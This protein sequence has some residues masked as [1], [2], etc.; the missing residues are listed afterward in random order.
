MKLTKRIRG[1]I[2]EHRYLCRCSRCEDH[3]V[4]G[5]WPAKVD[6][7]DGGDPVTVLPHGSVT[8][9]PEALAGPLP[10]RVTK[11]DFLL[12]TQLHMS[13]LID[14]DTGFSRVFKGDLGDRVPAIA[15]AVGEDSVRVESTG[16]G[17]VVAEM[18]ADKGVIVHKVMLRSCS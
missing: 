15:D 18:L 7:G 9:I 3:R 12:D 17:F 5:D 16:I 10:A 14:L 11:P 4:W 8:Q 2:P 13:L 1:G 6:P